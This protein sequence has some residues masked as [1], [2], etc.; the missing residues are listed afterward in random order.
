MHGVSLEGASAV[1]LLFVGSRQ[2]VVLQKRALGPLVRSTRGLWGGAD[3]GEAGYALTFAIAYIRDFGLDYRILSE[4]LETLAPWSVVGSV[5]PAVQAAVTEEH[6]ALRIPG[7]PFLSVR[8]TQLYDEGAVLYM[9]MAVS[10]AGLAPQRALEVFQRLEHAARRAIL[11][12]GG[13]LSHHHGVGKIRAELLPEGL[14]PLVSETAR[15]VKAV[16]DPHNVL[17]AGNGAW[18]TPPPMTS[19][20][21][22]QKELSCGA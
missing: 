16:L 2:E 18:W 8:M 17:G 10:T 4:S 13:C 15:G 5:W 11:D 22:S 1:T 9:Y 12:A 20:P 14:A 19:Q 6:R 21:P 7:R 3:S